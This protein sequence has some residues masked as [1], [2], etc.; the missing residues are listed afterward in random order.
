MNSAQLSTLWKA[1]FHEL[2]RA[3]KQVA[4]LQELIKEDRE[5]LTS[6]H[7]EK[8]MLNFLLKIRLH[9]NELSAIDYLNYADVLAEKMNEVKEMILPCGEVTMLQ[10]LIDVGVMTPEE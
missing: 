2:A 10:L 7:D 1:M 4:V 6:G 9:E 3:N 5:R 8:E